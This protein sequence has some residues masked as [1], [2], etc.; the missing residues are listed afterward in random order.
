MCLFQKKPFGELKLDT[1]TD[2]RVFIYFYCA[3]A[4]IN[5]SKKQHYSNYSYEQGTI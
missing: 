4:N 5:P 1:S 3:V 2:N